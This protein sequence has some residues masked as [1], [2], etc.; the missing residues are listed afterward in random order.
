M[1][2]RDIARGDANALEGVAFKRQPTISYT[3]D[4]EIM[5]WLFDAI[6]SAPILGV[7]T[8]AK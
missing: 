8:P 2:I 1:T 3:K 6:T 7:G 4:G 5:T